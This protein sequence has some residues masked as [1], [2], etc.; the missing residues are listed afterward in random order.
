[1]KSRKKTITRGIRSKTFFPETFSKTIFQKLFPEEPKTK[2]KSRKTISRGSK[3]NK[4][5]KL[6]PEEADQKQCI[7][8]N[9]FD[10]LN[11]NPTV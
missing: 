9:A 8:Q 6:F 7:F 1:M 4:S 10:Q 2:M 5:R 11:Q 3:K